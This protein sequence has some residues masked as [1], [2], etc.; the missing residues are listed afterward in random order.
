VHPV[1][2][3][4]FQDAPIFGTQPISSFRSSPN[5]CRVIHVPLAT[6]VVRSGGM[7]SMHKLIRKTE[8]QL[9]RI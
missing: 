4:V 1:A 3:T 8:S 2:N 6:I 7:C 9:K 5:Y